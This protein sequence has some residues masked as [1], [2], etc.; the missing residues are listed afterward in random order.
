[1][2]GYIHVKV[3]E[4]INLSVEFNF[5]IRSYNFWLQ[6]DSIFEAKSVVL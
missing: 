4:T 1:M 6:V 2:F 3:C 5:R